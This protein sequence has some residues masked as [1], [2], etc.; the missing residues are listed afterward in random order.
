MVNIINIKGKYL[1]ALL[2]A[3]VLLISACS[4]TN[5][6]EK[7]T[8]ELKTKE[9]KV[10]SKP[11]LVPSQ[12]TIDED[13]ELQYGSSNQPLQLLAGTTTPYYRFDKAHFQKSLEEGKV[14]F[15]DFHA[16]WCPVCKREHPNIVAA[17][18][19]LSNPDVV[20]YQVHYND[21]ET[22][23]DD[24][25]MAKKYGI[26]SQYTKVI[27]DKNGEVALR[28]LEILNKDRIINEIGKVAGG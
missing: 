22:T 4:Q 25:K 10:T 3:S 20:G 21:R 18:N 28:T 12:E 11:I 27:V 23:A 8:S 17:F 14:V 16:D 1:F 9:A 26:V 2:I 15:L 6:I 13:I 24:I 7:Q 5:S 19:E